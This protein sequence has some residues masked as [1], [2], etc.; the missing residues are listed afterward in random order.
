MIKNAQV[1]VH[2]FTISHDDI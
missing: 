2:R 1:H